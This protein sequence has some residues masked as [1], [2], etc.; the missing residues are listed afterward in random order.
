MLTMAPFSWPHTKHSRSSRWPAENSW[1]SWRRTQLSGLPVFC[2]SG[3]WGWFSSPAPCTPAS[4]S[5]AHTLTSARP[6]FPREGRK[7]RPASALSCPW[8]FL[9]RQLHFLLCAVGRMAFDCPWLK[10][11]CSALSGGS[12]REEALRLP[13]SLWLEPR[14]R[15][16]GSIFIPCPTSRH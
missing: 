8:A 13:F 10:V 7:V 12:C 4:A 5:S 2:L 16:G 15:G 6:G 11:L 3:F 9:A 1:D 14:G